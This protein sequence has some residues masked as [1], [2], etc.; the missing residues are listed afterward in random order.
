MERPEHRYTNPST[1]LH[2][3]YAR[4]AQSGLLNEI[5]FFKFCQWLPMQPSVGRAANMHAYC[6]I[7]K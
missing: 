5:Q 4:N 7:C 6:M 3:I 2:Y 1:D